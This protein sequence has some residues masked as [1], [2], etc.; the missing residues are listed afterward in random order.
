MNRQ[1]FVVIG[2]LC[3]AI[4]FAGPV[5]VASDASPEADE[6]AFR[7]LRW[8]DP[9]S[10]LGESRKFGSN[11][12]LDVYSKIGENLSL[13]SLKVN[14]IMYIFF[15]DQ[16]QTVIFVAK[17]VT[18]TR[19]ILEA[20]YGKPAVSSQ[21]SRDAQWL[22]GDTAVHLKEDLLEETARVTLMS[23]SVTTRWDEWKK[24]QASDDADAW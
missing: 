20:K 22:I 9:P 16:L 6:P 11:A 15:Q 14:S 2:V 4:A 17:D 21:F 7:D 3:A 13:G 24:K 10:A 5:S 8:G 19:E 1:M 23:V 18:K 12:G